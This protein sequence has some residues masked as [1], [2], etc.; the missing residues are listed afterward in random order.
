MSIRG[1]PLYDVRLLFFSFHDGPDRSDQ[2]D[3]DDIVD[4][5]ENQRPFG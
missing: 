5:F 2:L 3:L 4:L 1:N